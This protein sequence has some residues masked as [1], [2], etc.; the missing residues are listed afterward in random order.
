MEHCLVTG[1]SGFLGSQLC[2][3][4]TSLGLNVTGMD[5]H[6]AKEAVSGAFDFVSGNLVTGE[7][8]D[9]LAWERFDAVFH[10]AAAGVKAATREWQNCIQVNLLG[11]LHLIERLEQAARRPTLVYTHTYYEDFIAT[12]PSLAASPYVMSKYAATQVVRQF[13]RNY[14]GCTV[15]A[16]V[17]QIYGAGDAQGNLIPYVLGCL[18]KGEPARLGSGA[19]LRDWLTV[20]DVAAGLTA[21]W[22]A[23][24]PGKLREFDLGSGEFVAIRDVLQR[25]ASML[26]K[27]FAGL[28]FD[29]AR[30]RDDL[31]AA[32]K[33]ERWP[34]HWRPQYDLEQGLRR[35]IASED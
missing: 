30:D 7:G 35:L 22:R 19:G 34:D 33:A 21:C 6:P 31:M 32:G 23:G 16:K 1:S 4:L 26:G 29:A 15:L 18:R 25:L 11:T 28:D 9:L 20:E 17:F 13:A 24:S 5:V 27:P 14:P 2:R 3:H 8:L 10:L 12:S